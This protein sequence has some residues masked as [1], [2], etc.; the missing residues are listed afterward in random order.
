MRCSSLHPESCSARTASLLWRGR[1]RS[2]IEG[3][4][5][6][7]A[8]VTSHHRMMHPC[9]PC[10]MSPRRLPCVSC[11]MIDV[12]WDHT[13][14]E[15]D[16]STSQAGLHQGRAC[17]AGLGL[18]HDIEACNS[19]KSAPNSNSTWYAT[20]K[21]KKK[22]TLTRLYNAQPLDSICRSL[23]L[24]SRTSTGNPRKKKSKV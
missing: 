4:G 9:V 10:V 19:D 15:G 8:G 17:R 11:A 23:G 6:K 22:H 2:T 13:L 21:E 16:D 14:F 1:V 12:L 7:P 3:V 20:R 5:G 24:P 18:Q